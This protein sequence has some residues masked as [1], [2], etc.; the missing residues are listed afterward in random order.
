MKGDLSDSG[1][2]VAALKV[3][4]FDAPSGKFRFDAHQNAVLN[5][6]VRKVQPGAGGQLANVPIDVLNG[7]EQY[8][9]KGRPATK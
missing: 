8:W 1:K 2:F 4:Q 5:L 3:V 7:V 9:P 6:Y